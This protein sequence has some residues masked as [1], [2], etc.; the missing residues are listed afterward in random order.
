MVNLGKKTINIGKGT[1]N[2]GENFIELLLA[3]YWRTLDDFHE[4][5]NKGVAR[6]CQDAPKGQERLTWQ[7]L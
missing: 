2:L 6:R 7:R 5:A 3:S 1:M 4:T